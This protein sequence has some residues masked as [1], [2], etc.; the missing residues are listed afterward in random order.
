LVTC[1]LRLSEP[2]ERRRCSPLWSSRRSTA[3][4]PANERVDTHVFVNDAAHT[5]TRHRPSRRARGASTQQEGLSGDTMDIPPWTPA[6]WSGR[7]CVCD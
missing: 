5:Q 2:L 1:W 6:R 7:R 3:A 4:E